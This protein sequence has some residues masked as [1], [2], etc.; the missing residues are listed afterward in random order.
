MG[1]SA[2][3]HQRFC[4]ESKVGGGEGVAAS[5]PM[6]YEPRESIYAFTFGSVDH[7][8]LAMLLLSFGSV[9]PRSIFAECKL[10]V[11]QQVSEVKTALSDPSILIT[12]LA[13]FKEAEDFHGKSLALHLM[14]FIH[15]TVNRG[16]VVI[17]DEYHDPAWGCLQCSALRRNFPCISECRHMGLQYMVIPSASRASV[18]LRDYTHYS[19]IDDVCCDHATYSRWEMIQ[20]ANS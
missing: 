1:S 18:I 16:F 5:A 10:D 13:T 9:C 12:D 4:F 8:S 6:V 2:F 17:V 7:H 15:I 14:N 20:V 3:P 11:E 19:E